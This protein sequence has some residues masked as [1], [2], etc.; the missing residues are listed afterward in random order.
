MTE[1]QIQ[2]LGQLPWNSVWEDSV[3]L[4]ISRLWY[5]RIEGRTASQNSQ[6]MQEGRWEALTKT[7]DRGDFE[8]GPCRGEEYSSEV[9]LIMQRDTVTHFGSQVIFTAYGSQ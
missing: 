3:G 5:S 1:M 4:L 6:G 7:Q 2:S 9:N 8:I